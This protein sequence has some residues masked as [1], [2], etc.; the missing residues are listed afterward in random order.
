LNGWL[1]NAEGAI[2]ISWG[3]AAPSSNLD[4]WAARVEGLSG[5]K[6][7]WVEEVSRVNDNHLPTSGWRVPTII[8]WI[9]NH[10]KVVC[11]SG[12]KNLALKPRKIRC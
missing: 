1:W 11:I 4:G 6:C 2:R 10:H 9:E 7:G 5:S 8:G 12:L 3:G